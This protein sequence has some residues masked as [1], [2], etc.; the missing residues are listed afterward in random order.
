MVR[1]HRNFLT[2]VTPSSCSAAFPHKHGEAH[3]LR[4]NPALCFPKS[5]PR[6]LFTFQIQPHRGCPLAMAIWTDRQRSTRWSSGLSEVTEQESGRAQ[7]QNG[8]FW[9]LQAILSQPTAMCLSARNGNGVTMKSPSRFLKCVLQISIS[10]LKKS[11]NNKEYAYPQKGWLLRAVHPT[12]FIW[13]SFSVPRSINHLRPGCI[14][15]GFSLTRRC[16]S[17]C[18]PS[19]ETGSAMW[20][21]LEG[22]HVTRRRRGMGTWCPQVTTP[23][24]SER[25]TLKSLERGW[26]GDTVSVQGRSGAGV[27]TLSSHV[28]GSECKTMLWDFVVSKYAVN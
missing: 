11:A 25:V 14:T 20:V 15:S 17:V 3:F 27:L 16:V 2:L 7:I 5:C 26:R 28:Y 13:V 4:V 9:Y 19:L 22:H 21:E 24:C 1:L 6:T 23:A 18:F 12:F 8:A 10:N